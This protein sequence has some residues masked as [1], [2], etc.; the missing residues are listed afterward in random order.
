MNSIAPSPKKYAH[1]FEHDNTP[2]KPS[3]YF[4]IWRP[5]RPGTQDCGFH[6]GKFFSKSE[7]E[8][9][10]VKINMELD[11]G[12]RE[13]DLFLKHSLAKNGFAKHGQ[14]TSLGVKFL[15]SAASKYQAPKWHEANSCDD[16]RKL[17]RSFHA[18]FLLPLPDLSNPKNLQSPEEK[19]ELSPSEKGISFSVPILVQAPDREGWQ[20]TFERTHDNKIIWSKNDQTAV[21]SAA[22]D[23]MEPIKLI[24]PKLR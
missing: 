9:V 17:I 13:L 4:K 20:K 21:Y 24:K 2:H 16:F 14:I 18:Q 12:M 23:R 22:N 6:Y 10:A 3:S 5:D 11:A 1:A 19:R 8:F 7:A 15:S